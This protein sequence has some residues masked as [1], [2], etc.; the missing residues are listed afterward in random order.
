MSRAAPLLLPMPL[1]PEPPEVPPPENVPRPGVLS[2]LWNRAVLWWRGE[3]RPLTPLE[4]RLWAENQSLRY[5]LWQRDNR[6]FQLEHDLSRKD[7]ENK[8]LQNE[9]TLWVE[10]HGRDRA[11]NEADAAA[12]AAA[13]GAI[14][15]CRPQV[16]RA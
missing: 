8:V 14:A 12:Y 16:D 9:V 1:L 10:V 2:R 11:R 13:A 5:E 3:A 4:R 15:A 7:S 6:V